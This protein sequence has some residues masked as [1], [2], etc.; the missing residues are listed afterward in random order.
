MYDNPAYEDAS[1]NIYDYID[2]SFVKIGP[3]VVNNNQA[4]ATIKIGVSNGAT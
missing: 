3:I 2:Q 4:Y 1:R